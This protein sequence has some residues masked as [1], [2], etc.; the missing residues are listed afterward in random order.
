MKGERIYCTGD[1]GRMQDDGSVVFLGRRDH[2]IK[3]R[4]YRVETREIENVLNGYTS[5]EQAVVLVPEQVSSVSSVQAAI[6]L[7][8]DFVYDEND[9]RQWLSRRLPAYMIPSVFHVVERFPITSNGKT[10]FNELRRMTG[11]SNETSRSLAPPRDLTEL[12]LVNI[13]RAILKQEEIGI[14]DGFFDLGGH[15]LLA[16]QLFA[17]IEKEFDVHLP[18]ATL[19]ERGS[20]MALAE[21]LRE[22][23]LTQKP[24]SLVPIR[25]GNGKK[26]LYLVHPAG[27]NV[28]CYY[29][30]AR[31]LGMDYSIYGL[32]ASGLSGKKVDS[33]SDMARFYLEEINLPAGID[34]VV[35]AGWSMGA[36]IAFEMARQVGETSGVNPRLM[37]IDQI[38]PVEAEPDHKAITIDPVDRMLV[39][40]GKVA[41]LVGRPLGINATDLRGKEPVAQS[42]VFLKAFKWANLV[43]PDMKIS[44]FHGYLDLMIHHNEITAACRPG[45]FDGKT[46]LIRA[47]DA[48]PPFDGQTV[49]PER[50]YD[51]DWGRWI[52]HDLSV[53]DI[54][55]NHVSVIVRPYV[56]ELALALMKWGDTGL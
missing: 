52:K 41:H 11:T 48:L 47:G 29:D 38:A 12:R 31:E 26:Q 17:S 18:L 44:D 55:G 6:S 3:I 30:L 54:P 33:V 8:Q 13:F 51:L 43:P 35:F 53:V 46:L 50:S 25:P 27:G 15:S 28:L 23:G 49:V 21:L 34:D 36:L 5:V 14:G 7:K 39:F 22:S 32:Q 45:S 2:Q 40:A 19:F 16:I 56:K 10:D 9:L 1:L 20:V 4:G 24:S 42:E 37:I